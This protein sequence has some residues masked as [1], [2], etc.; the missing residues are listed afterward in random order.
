MKRKPAPPFKLK[1]TPVNK[2]KS[3]EEV[4]FENNFRETLEKIIFAKKG[5]I[6]KDK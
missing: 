1:I 5:L 4:M 3:I 2:N 6:N